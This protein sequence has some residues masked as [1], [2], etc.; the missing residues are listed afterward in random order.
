M[1][2]VSFR[3]RTPLAYCVQSASLKMVLPEFPD[4]FRAPARTV[5]LQGEAFSAIAGTNGFVN[6]LGQRLATVLG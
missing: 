1:R 6:G 2:Q 4:G 5:P 3:K